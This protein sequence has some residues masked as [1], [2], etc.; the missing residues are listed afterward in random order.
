M[1]YITVCLSIFMISACNEK[2]NDL[3]QKPADSLE[4]KE[5]KQ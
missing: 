3:N 4:V 2:N 1:K 5:M